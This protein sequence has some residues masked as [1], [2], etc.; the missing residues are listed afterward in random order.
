MKTKAVLVAS[1]AA[2]LLISGAVVAR[3]DDM[4]GAKQVKCMGINSCKG[5]GA[6]KSAQNDCKGKNG[7][8]GQGMTM[9][10]PQDCKAKGGKAMA[11]SK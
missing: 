9:T 4:G 11:E 10:T 7:C 8:K 3:A 2:V 1:A 6:C 5:H